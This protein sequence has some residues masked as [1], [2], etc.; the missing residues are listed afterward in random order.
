CISHGLDEDRPGIPQSIKEHMLYSPLESSPPEHLRKRVHGDESLSNF[1]NA[2]RLISYNIHSSIHS[3]NESYENKRIL[4]FGCGCGRLI[5]Y[6]SRFSDN[7]NFYG[8][9][10]DDEA[11]T[12]C[13]NELSNMGKFLTN[14]VMPPLPFDDNFFD[15]IYS[16]S[17]FTHLP[18]EMQFA[19]L[20]ELGRITKRGGYLLLTTH[21]EELLNKAPKRYQKQLKNAGFLYSKGDG[22]DGLPDFYQ[23]S[24]HTD[25]YIQEHWSNYFQIDKIIK[26]RD[27]ESPGFGNL[28]E[29]LTHFIS[30]YWRQTVH[31]ITCIAVLV[32]Y[33]TTAPMTVTRR[34]DR[35]NGG[36]GLVPRSRNRSPSS[37]QP[38]CNI[39]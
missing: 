12:W 24:F 13:Q 37:I 30:S 25:A 17:V 15:V 23:T 1:E 19:W 3:I 26:K 35:S 7:N 5:K 11:I 34:I 18:E 22:T 16:I 29:A 32:N 28:Q 14:K 9:D 39:L 8:T 21:G 6:L 38:Y 31:A 2:G 20:E 10:I 27:Y 33:S 36:D 4:D